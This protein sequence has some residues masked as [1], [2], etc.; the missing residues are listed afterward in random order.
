MRQTHLFLLIVLTLFYPMQLVSQCTMQYVGPDDKNQASYYKAIDVDMATNSA[1]IPYLVFSDEEKDFKLTVRKF[2]NNTWTTV[3]NAGFTPW[4]A[5]YPSITIDAGGVPYIAYSESTNQQL[6][7]KKFNGTSWVNVGIIPSNFSG[8]FPK[9]K[10]GPGG[11]PYVSYRDQYTQKMTVIKLT[12]STWTTVGNSSFSGPLSGV[13]PSD[14][15][16]DPLGQ[17]YVVY[18]DGNSGNKATVMTYTSGTWSV[19]GNAG[20]T[21][22]A[23]Y[24]CTITLGAGNNLPYIASVSL[25]QNPQI[26]TLQFNGNNWITIGTPLPC[27]TVLS[28]KFVDLVVDNTNAVFVAGSISPVVTYSGNTW[29][30]VGPNFAT[31]ITEYGNLIKT[32]SGDLLLS[33]SSLG[34]MKKATLLKYN[35]TTWTV[36]APGFP[37]I[38]DGQASYSSI[39]VDTI[40]DIPYIAYADHAYNDYLCVK[41]YINNTWVDVG[42]PGFTGFKC[43]FISIVFDPKRTPHVVFNENSGPSGINVRVMKF[44]GT[45]W[46]NVGNPVHGFNPSLVFD[47]IGVPY[48]GF[49]D[50]WN[51]PLSNAS[52]M[53]LNGTNWTYV[54][55]PVLSAGN[56]SS[57]QMTID[58]N[59][60]LY[61]AYYDLPN[62]GITVKKYTGTNWVDI[63]TPGSIQG[64]FPSIALSSNGTPYISFINASTSKLSVMTYSN[65][66]WTS[67]GGLFS[68]SSTANFPCIKLDNHNTPYVSFLDIDFNSPY[69]AKA[70]LI[71]Y[72]FNTALWNRI[73]LSEFS[74]GE[75]RFN[76][77]ALGKNNTPYI[78]F[79]ETGVFVVKNSVNGQASVSPSVSICP[80][81]PVNFNASGGNTYQWTGPNGYTSTQA[82]PA[83]A[84][85]SVSNSGTYSVS[86]SYPGCSTQTLTTNLSVLSCIGVSENNKDAFNLSIYPNPAHHVINIVSEEDI[87]GILSIYALN[88]DCIYKTDING[89]STNVNTEDWPK[90]VYVLTIRSTNDTPFI[91]K[92]VL[93]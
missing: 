28:N 14:M 34:N 82:T 29:V 6:Y 19:L 63:G 3:G 22:S 89:K 20:L 80:G 54:G 64:L 76:T 74:S 73:G 88:G 92:L 39:A 52:V 71:K 32:V 33:G 12:G 38:S 21:P 93:H 65:A 72:D 45:S 91:R 85:A 84:S 50:Y 36:Q 11:I 16:I 77:L 13:I 62:N 35:G 17:I 60:T 15:V 69:R 24:R 26:E 1:G 83:I 66:T 51:N 5:G 7:V 90:G 79:C 9:I 59:D 78:T 47:H 18:A 46:V 27:Q 67:I 53:K 57:P 23:I 31:Q 81:N 56:A 30:Q 86:I 61:V 75:T 25:S 40:A 68:V 37:G 2:E 41:K 58:S 43:D 44:N 10:I 4:P 70:A 49:Q 48:I 8:T 87:K 42:P 55:N